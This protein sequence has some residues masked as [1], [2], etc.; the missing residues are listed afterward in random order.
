MTA[1][2]RPSRRAALKPSRHAGLKVSVAVSDIEDLVQ[3]SGSFQ[4]RPEHRG[5]PPFEPKIKCTAKKDL[6]DEGE[7]LFGARVK[8]SMLVGESED[9]Q[10][11]VRI[12]SEFLV[13]YRIEGLS[14]F[15]SKELTAFASLNGRFNAWPY[16]RE[17]VQ[18]SL[19]RMGLPPFVVPPFKAFQESRRG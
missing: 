3:V 6:L 5:F 17:F 7:G 9:S 16:W 1:A 14:G 11:F 13:I 15:S 12:R 4:Y 10:W 19:P 18:S 2:K 8:F